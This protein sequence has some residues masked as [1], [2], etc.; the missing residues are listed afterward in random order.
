VINSS[1]TLEAGMLGLEAS[2]KWRGTDNVRATLLALPRV[3]ARCLP[4]HAPPPGRIALTRIG[5]P[6]PSNDNRQEPRPGAGG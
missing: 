6:G 1:V 3:Y 2:V 5:L 4:E